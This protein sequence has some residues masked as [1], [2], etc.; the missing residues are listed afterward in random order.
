MRWKVLRDEG[1]VALTEVAIVMPVVLL[2]FL[3]ILQYFVIVRTAQLVNYAAYA[4][5]RSYAVH[6]SVD[7]AASATATATDAAAWALAPVANLAPGELAGITL[8]VPSS[9]LLKLGEG[10]LVARYL[11]LNPQFGGSITITPTPAGNPTQVEVD[12]AYPQ[13]IGIWGLAPLWNTIGHGGNIQQDL[14]PLQGGLGGIT[15]AS[16][17]VAQQVQGGISGAEPQGFEALFPGVWGDFASS[18]S[19]LAG[20]AVSA[21][22]GSVLPFPYVNV[23]GKCYM[24]YENWGS[25]GSYTAAQ[26][27]VNNYTQWS[28]WGSSSAWQARAPEQ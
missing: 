17:N 15:G 28:G 16:N 13:P 23:P 18:V 21:L 12:I 6:A 2:F 19:N 14:R 4:A 7:G 20:N 9:N 11:R 8:P 25:Q 10:F 24:E 26:A 5:A 27:S 3:A 22:T 1:G